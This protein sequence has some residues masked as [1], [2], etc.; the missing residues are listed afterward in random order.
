MG[1]ALAAHNGPHELLQ[2]VGISHPGSA[3]IGGGAAP[4][5][6]A[7]G[8]SNRT[9]DG[10]VILRSSGSVTVMTPKAITRPMPMIV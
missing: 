3:G 4:P 5:P 8:Y 10:A 7:A 1:N 6:P 2:L 9:V